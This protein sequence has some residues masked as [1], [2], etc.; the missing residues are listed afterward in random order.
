[1]EDLVNA[2]LPE[3]ESKDTAELSENAIDASEQVNTDDSAEAKE[4]YTVDENT[5]NA[6]PEEHSQENESIEL[7]SSDTDANS[8]EDET[9]VEAEY[10]KEEDSSKKQSKDSG[11]RGIDFIFDILEIF[12]FSLA[13]VLIITTFLF[14]H[15]VVDGVSMENTLHAGEHLIISNLFYTPDYGDI[16]VCEEYG[17]LRKPI[18]KRIIALPGDHIEV[19]ADYSVYLNGEKLEEEY[20]YIDFIGNPL[21]VDMIVPEGEVFIMGDHRNNSQDSRSFGTVDIDSILGKVLLRFY[22]FDQFGKI[23]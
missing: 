19:R 6:I 7:N 8:I 3:E 16:I 13:T 1:M 9:L 4:T 15:S 21:E 11:E 22:P 23:K 18:V 2:P 17:T 12:I 5:E 20:V 14:R 10:T